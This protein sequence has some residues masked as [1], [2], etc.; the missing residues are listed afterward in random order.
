MCMC[1][2]V[3]ADSY[4]ELKPWLTDILLSIGTG[5]GLRGPS[6]QVD[7]GYLNAR[8]LVAL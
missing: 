6:F 1:M 5:A 3:R 7:F 2:C 8:F 4:A